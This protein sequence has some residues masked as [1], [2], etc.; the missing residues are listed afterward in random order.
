MV[1]IVRWLYFQGDRNERFV[2][3]VPRLC[4]GDPAGDGGRDGAP[5][6]AAPAHDGHRGTQVIRRAA[7]NAGQ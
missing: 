3:I 1:L 5:G 2:I 4:A 6:Q 7:A